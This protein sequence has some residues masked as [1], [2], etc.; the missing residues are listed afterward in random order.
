MLNFKNYIL[1]VL[2]LHHD[3]LIL[4]T[5]NSPVVFQRAGSM[6]SSSSDSI[7]ARVECL[8]TLSHCKGWVGESSAPLDLPDICPRKVRSWLLPSHFLQ[9]GTKLRSPMG[10]NSIVHREAGNRKLT[11]TALLLPGEDMRSAPH[12]W[13]Q[14]GGEKRIIWV[15]HVTLLFS[16]AGWG[17]YWVKKALDFV[18]VESLCWRKLSTPLD[19]TDP[20]CVE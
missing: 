7:L 6:Y 15:L 18:S 9:E 12:Y 2:T 4:L 13:T 14:T 5:E 1:T 16:K 11:H 10:T 19:L 8:G 3:T 20:T 17:L